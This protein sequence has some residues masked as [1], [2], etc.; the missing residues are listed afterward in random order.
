MVSQKIASS[1]FLSIFYYGRP[2]S[3][4][5]LIILSFSTI[6]H[7]LLDAYLNHNTGDSWSEQQRRG[8]KSE[9]PVCNWEGVS[10]NTNGEI[11][12]LS[13]PAIGF[14]IITSDSDGN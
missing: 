13:F 4:I 6:P 14:P 2:Y 5:V 1:A 8:W 7:L 12:G 3:N 9:L 11:N 10:C